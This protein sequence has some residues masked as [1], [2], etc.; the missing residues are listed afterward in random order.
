[1]RCWLEG[2]GLEDC[3]QGFSITCQLP[4]TLHISISSVLAPNM[5]S[6]YCRGSEIVRM[7]WYRD[8][9]DA[10]VQFNVYFVRGTKQMLGFIQRTEDSIVAGN[11]P[12]MKT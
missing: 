4:A 2:V 5:P 9:K 1:V 6:G 8:G 3:E 7:L 11:V 12:G 10:S